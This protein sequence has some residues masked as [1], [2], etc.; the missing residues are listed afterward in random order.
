MKIRSDYVS[1][2]SSSSFM[3]VGEVFSEDKIY[4]IGKKLGFVTDDDSGDTWDDD[5]SG[6]TWDIVEKIAEKFDIKYERGIENYYDEWCLGL[7]YGDMKDSETKKEFEKRVSDK[8]S[9]IT[10]Y[11]VDVAE[12]V[13]GGRDE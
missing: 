9:E 11:H 13:D 6:D 8:L 5:D 3:I 1:N 10:G 4:D 2:S 7:H 12:L